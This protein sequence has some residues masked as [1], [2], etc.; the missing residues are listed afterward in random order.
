VVKDLAFARVVGKGVGKED[1]AG[2]K[3]RGE[4]EDYD[5]TLALAL[6]GLGS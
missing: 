2:I 3:D 1:T 4:G 5:S 6:S